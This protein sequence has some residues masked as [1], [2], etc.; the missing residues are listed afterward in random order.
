VIR[1]STIWV[2][3]LALMVMA[4]CSAP[5][6]ESSG[7]M[8]KPAESSTGGAPDKAVST[9]KAAA[10]DT[11]A[12]APGDDAK[13]ANPPAVTPPVKTDP[14]AKV[15]PANPDDKTVKVDKKNP[16][17][18]APPQ[19]N[20]PRKLTEKVP[21]KPRPSTPAVKVA[22]SGNPAKY[23]GK[24]R[25]LMMGKQDVA[26]LQAQMKAKK[27][28]GLV[29]ELEIKA[30][31]TYVWKFGPDRAVR[32]IT[33]TVQVSDKSVT[34]SPYMADDEVAS[35][36]ADKMAFNLE[37]SEGGKKLTTLVRI[38]GGANAKPTQLVFGRL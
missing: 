30:D 12:K 36:P 4:G 10:Q 1:K 9:D 23:V 35:R 29:A 15:S 18:V 17:S 8:P 7:G 3:V 27:A 20:D 28:P 19:P 25:L 32:T 34:L 2:T 38:S 14:A 16:D 33:G 26:K 24:Y 11:V 13:P 6:K 31:G 5:P 37:P 22:S 21:D